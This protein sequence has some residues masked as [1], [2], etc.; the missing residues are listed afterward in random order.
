MLT[1]DYLQSS[2]L[3]EALNAVD[4]KVPIDIVVRGWRARFVAMAFPYFLEIETN[5]HVFFRRIWLLAKFV[6]SGAFFT[7][8]L[9][10][11]CNHAILAGMLVNSS[12]VSDKFVVVCRVKER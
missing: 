5:R 11:I 6:L 10:G 7:P 2:V 4:R 3:Q 9:W 8:T 1:F 12:S